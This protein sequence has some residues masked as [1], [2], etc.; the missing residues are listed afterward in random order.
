MD[1]TC[2]GLQHFSAILRDPVG[3]RYVNLLG[4]GTD[5]E[6]QDIYARVGQNATQVIEQD[7]HDSDP[8]KARM[9]LWWQ[10]LGIPRGMAKKPVMTYVYGA[11]LRCSVDFVDGYVHDEMGEKFPENVRGYDCAAFAAK[12]LFQGIAATVPAAAAAMQ[13]LKNVAK[14]MPKGQRMEW[15]SPTGFLVQHD[16][17]DYDEVKVRL[18]SC[19]VEQVIVREY[20]EDTKTIPMQNAIAPNFV[21]ALDGAHLVFTALD[22]KKRDLRIVGIHDSFGTHA[23]DVSQMHSAI[24]GSFVQ[25]YQ[26]RNVLAEF[27]WEVNGVGEVP[28]RGTLDLEQVLESEF[29][30]C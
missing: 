30:F 23:C 10:H 24:R 14:Q 1:A 9:A 26:G 15:H 29:F 11:T 20:N 18:R 19:G 4:D 2:S 6:K 16:Y 22:M 7:T 21:H 27:L 3:G 5:E 13:W 17:Q 12:K 28:M 25:L 8:A